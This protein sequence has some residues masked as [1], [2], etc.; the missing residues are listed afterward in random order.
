MVLDEKFHAAFVRDI[1]LGLEYLH[2]SPIGYHGSLTPWACVIDRNWSV[3]L[4]DFGIANPLERWEKEGAVTIEQAQSDDDKSQAAQRT[5]PL[6]C[7]PEMLKN[8]EQN[9]RRRM[10]QKWIAQSSSRR[11]AGDIYAFGM[12]MY[13]ILFRAMPYPQ[14]TDI[15]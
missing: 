8:R 1:T 13:E 7:A 12:V 9:R 3:R 5:S 15:S 14:C 10:D 11:Q 4:T 6:Y 2:T